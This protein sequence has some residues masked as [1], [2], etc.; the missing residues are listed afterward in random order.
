MKPIKF[1][2]QNVV[3]GKGQKEYLPLPAHRDQQGIITMCIELTQED[4]RE[5]RKTGKIWAQLS[6]FNQPLQPL[7]FMTSKPTMERNMP[8][9][10]ALKKIELQ[11]I[12]AAKE[13][14]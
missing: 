3:Y 6:T 7:Q 12:K 10:M 5:A 4:I 13:N 8:L 14:E 11:E 9:E 2:E 1:K